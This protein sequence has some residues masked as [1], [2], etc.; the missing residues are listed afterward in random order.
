ME[1][2]VYASDILSDSSLSSIQSY[3]AIKYGV[4]LDQSIVSNNTYRFASSEPTPVWSKDSLGIFDENIA[5]IG[6]D[7]SFPLYQKQ[8][9]SANA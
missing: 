8:A 3:L 2:M 5:G 9:R 7:N 6:R 4:T 1:I